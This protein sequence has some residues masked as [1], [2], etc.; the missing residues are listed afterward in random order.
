MNLTLNKIREHSPCQEGWEKLL[1]SKGKTK[2]DDE[3]FSILDVLESNGFEGALWCLRCITGYDREIRLFA[4]WC[5]K[6]VEH[7]NPDPRVKKCNDVAEQFAN[8]L[9]TKEQLADARAN[10]VNAAT[11]AWDYFNYVAC[12]AAMAA[13]WAAKPDCHHAPTVSVWAAAAAR[14]S[15]A[16]DK[17]SFDVWNAAMAAQKQKF[18]EMV[19]ETENEQNNEQSIQSHLRQTDDY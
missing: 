4:V 7:L 14:D 2:A 1:R 15:R 17:K 9:A 5:A 10:A 8:G 18:F 11:Y 3:E 16:A 12:S 19:K 6:Q 13:A